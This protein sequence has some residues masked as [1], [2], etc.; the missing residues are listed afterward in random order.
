MPAIKAI[1]L[2]SDR[3]ENDEISKWC[4][5]E[6][7]STPLYKRTI[8]SAIK[9]GIKDFIFFGYNKKEE[10][11]NSIITDRRISADI[12]WYDKETH[13]HLDEVI[14]SEL[15]DNANKHIF[16]I[17]ANTLFDYR[18]LNLL[19]SRSVNNTV[20]TISINNVA[21]INLTIPVSAGTD[22]SFWQIPS[23]NIFTKYHTGNLY[24]DRHEHHPCSHPL[25]GED[26]VEVIKAKREL[27]S[28]ELS[29][30]EN[31]IINTS[32]N[33]KVQ[34]K[35]NCGIIVLSR[36]IKD[37]LTAANC[38]FS[39]QSLTEKLNKENLLKTV[40]ISNY[41]YE[42]VNS[43]FDFLQAEKKLYQSLGSTLD[44]PILDKYV[45]RKL[46]GLISKL[47]ILTSVKP[48]QIT[49]MSLFFGLLAGFFFSLGGYIYNLTAGLLYFFSVILDQCD[50]E[51]A[52]LKF[53]ES[54]FGNAL[55]IICDTIVNAALVVGITFALYK[56]GNFGSIIIILSGISAVAGI[57]ISI[58]LTTWADVN[59]KDQM[60]DKSKKWLDKLNNKDFF[61][62]IIF[63][64]IAINQMIWFL[65]IMAIGTNIYWLT[66][67]IVHR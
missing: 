32:T 34:D 19:L 11:E 14:A 18:I 9:A 40:D 8:L 53:M 29:S 31:S 28:T 39:F 4:T 61:Y 49:I 59:N 64:C 44:S 20:A 24:K 23:K 26:K 10:I 58:F 7:A 21:H 27:F 3:L 22:R 12:K 37:Y 16:I 1:I 33:S 38:D 17:K 62:I 63:V 13:K 52:R 41:L 25:Q 48:N 47:L 65:L 43:Q 56:T 46:S 45:I 6:I 60:R 35:T 51:V 50:G 2:F 54:R 66:R 57:S 67:K 5:K 55:D 36:R 15:T 30:K 42:E